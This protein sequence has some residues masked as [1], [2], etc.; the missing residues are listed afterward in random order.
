[1]PP[2]A[3]VKSNKAPVSAP[4]AFV[5]DLQSFEQSL[6]G[7][8][9]QV[10]LPTEGVLVAVRERSRIFQ[11]ID[12]S[13]AELGYERI[14]ESLY[15]SKFLAAVAAGLF[16]AALNYLWDETI[17]E[18]RKRVAGY[19]LSYFFDLAVGSASEQRKSL[20]QEEDL[21]KV[22]DQDLIQAANRIGLVSDVGFQQLDLVRFMRNHASA[23]HPN[24]VE[25]RAM[26]LLNFLETCIVEVILLPENDAVVVI[27]RLL[28]NIK[29]QKLS[30]SDADTTGGT[31]DRLPEDQA[32]NLA[33]GLSGIYTRVDT[34]A[35]TRDNVRLI[36]PKLWPHLSE[37]SRRQFGVRALRFRINQDGTQAKLA[38]ELLE[39]VDGASYLPDELKIP[40]IELALE[41][42]KNS[43]EGWNNFTNEVA[44]ARALKRVVGNP[45]EVPES[46][47]RKY[48]NTVVYVFL[49]NGHG[50]SLSAS[51][52]YRELIEGFT[53]TQAKIALL[54][55]TDATVSSRLQHA[56][57]Q[58][59]WK[60]LLGL[61][62][63]KLIGRPA[64]R[65]FEALTNF[66]APLQNAKKDTSIKQLVRDVKS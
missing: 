49:T 42:L 57:A 40:E 1:M 63:K 44:P 21:S 55:F 62:E 17:S 22:T 66:S 47:E 11:N 52:I 32:D 14:A 24:Q 64:Q 4:Q 6:L 10:G 23:A 9:N 36:I 15:L 43:H 12:D 34:D 50:E 33:S 31:F 8:M 2:K 58:T 28:Q 56:L 38:R 13:L 51:P 20:K 25:L 45:P 29:T 30:Q 18:L 39:A 35:Q 5:A 53:P 27:R 19:D 16:D 65:L 41:D 48:V 54:S 7:R 59:Q 46:V 61:L 26:Q 37:D 3:L 60:E